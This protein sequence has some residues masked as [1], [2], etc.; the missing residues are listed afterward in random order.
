M[1]SLI[2][3]FQVNMVISASFGGV[4]PYIRPRLAMVIIVK[5]QKKNIQ[6]TETVDG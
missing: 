2:F 5:A 3:D 6:D 4:E 1:F